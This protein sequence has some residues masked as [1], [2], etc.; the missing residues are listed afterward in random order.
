MML[1]KPEINPLS[2]VLDMVRSEEKI[3]KDR[4]I[5]LFEQSLGTNRPSSVNYKSVHI[6]TEPSKFTNK[7]SQSI[8]ETGEIPLDF[9]TRQ[10]VL[11]QKSEQKKQAL[12][13]SLKASFRPMIDPNVSTHIPASKRNPNSMPIGTYLHELAR[14]KITEPSSPEPA[15][16]KPTLMSEN[17][18]NLKIKKFSRE[19][20]DIF[21]STSQLKGILMI[22]QIS[23]DRVDPEV[24]KLVAPLILELEKKNFNLDFEAFFS[25]FQEFYKSLPQSDKNLL[26]L[27]PKKQ[28]IDPNLTFKPK[29]NPRPFNPAYKP[30][31]TCLSEELC[32]PDQFTSEQ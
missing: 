32:F 24:L 11:A 1:E 15:I 23:I 20:F 4:N 28:F 13:E 26:L 12:K 14:E 18:M 25:V 27:P 30:H 16:V 5:R 6:E 19:L 31:K 22:S 10:K 8:L 2:R 17:L 9:F 21:S 7:T 3:I 29:T